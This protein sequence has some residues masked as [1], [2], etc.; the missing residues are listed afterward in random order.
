MIERQN[1]ATLQR[2]EYNM[3]YQGIRLDDYLKYTNT[4]MA[5]LRAQYT[6]EARRRVICQLI[7]DKIIKTENIK[8]E[9]S[10]I[11]AKIEEQAKSVDKTAEE[12]KKTMES[13]QK[14]Y[15]ENDIIV[16]KLF[17][18]LKSNNEMYTEEDGAEKASES[19]DGGAKTAKKANT[20][21]STTAK[22]AT[23]KTAKKVTTEKAEK[24]EKTFEVDAKAAAPKK[25]T[26]KQTEKQD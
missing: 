9:E 13:G 23:A 20:A 22:S 10:E 12:Y 16:T 4:D 7:I 15:I 17:D 24:A 8:A 14:E 21:K 6:T 19:A 26:A 25:R 1:E 2:M 5:A 3:M 18:F 11:E